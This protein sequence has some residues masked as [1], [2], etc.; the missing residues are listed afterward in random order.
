MFCFISNIGKF[1]RIY[2]TDKEGKSGNRKNSFS[3][4]THLFLYLSVQT[5]E[6]RDAG[7]FKAFASDLMPRACLATTQIRHSNLCCTRT[8]ACRS[9]SLTGFSLPALWLAVS[10]SSAG[11]PS[12]C[13]TL[14]LSPLCS[15]SETGALGRDD[16]RFWS[17]HLSST[18]QTKKER[19]RN[20]SSGATKLS[21]EAK[22]T[23]VLLPAEDA[24]N[25]M[26]Y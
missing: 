12:D 10:S 20:V 2:H 9:R 13:G 17:R 5:G 1:K 24:R 14:S 26:Q 11:P 7:I 4:N 15:T 16:S 23:V 22:C 21:P 3:I 18:W 6:C 25:E 19:K 8:C